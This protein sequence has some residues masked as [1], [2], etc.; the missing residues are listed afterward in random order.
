MNVLSTFS[1][2][3]KR[4]LVTGATRG[5]G[6]ALARALLQAGASVIITGRQ[7]S[8]LTQAVSLLREESDNVTG[9]LLD[10]TQT[11]QIAQAIASIGNIDILVNNAGTEQVCPSLEADEALWDTIVGTNL[12]GAF[13]CAQAAAKGM[14]ASGTGGVIINLCS[15]TSCVGVPGAAA[16]GSSKSGLVGLTRTLS[17]EWAG[18]NIRVNGIGPGYFETDMTQVFYQD[19]QW[20]NAMQQKIPL[21]RLG[22]LD[23]LAGSVVFLSSDAARYITGQI[24]YVDGGYL[25]A[26]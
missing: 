14:A 15:L 24:L 18:H 26:I 11:P 22:E 3:G 4:A 13:F 2:A 17:A 8:T 1:L 20:R 12:K 21:G 16:Y 25:A 23:D 5:I 6:F 9:L 10:V 19:E 7:Q